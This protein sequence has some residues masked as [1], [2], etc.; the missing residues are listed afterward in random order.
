MVYF[1]VCAAL[2]FFA[3]CGDDGL[4]MEQLKLSAHTVFGAYEEKDLAINDKAE[5][6]G[7]AAVI[8]EKDGRLL[9][10]TNSH[11]LSLSELSQTDPDNSPE[12]LSYR[13]V[14]QFA[15]GKRKPVLRFG[16]HNGA[17]DLA[18]LEVDAGGLKRGVDYVV[19]NDSGNIQLN[20]GD[21]V[22]AV[23]APLG[24]SGTH[25]FGHI[26]AIRVMEGRET[27]RLIQTDAAINPGNSGGPL[28]LRSGSKYKFMG[29]NTM[30]MA[31]ADNLGFAID[32]QHV[33]DSSYLWYKAD[34][35]GAQQGIKNYGK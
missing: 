21:E 19:L 34:A 7:S 29:V 3:G 1:T 4:S 31:D 20:E 22:V 5:W 35:Q 23:G 11:V 26:S 32:A 17:L 18:L 2:L 24:L 28:L 27:C 6:S 30:K 10:V 33:N 9:L 25:T 14:V 12:V 16:D 15:S 13:L 8:S